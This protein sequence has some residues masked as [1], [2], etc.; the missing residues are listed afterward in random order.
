M[1]SLSALA[2]RVS[3]GSQQA[4]SVMRLRWAAIDL[5][6]YAGTAMVSGLPLTPRSPSGGEHMAVT[7]YAGS[8]S[9]VHGGRGVVAEYRGL[10]KLIVAIYWCLFAHIVIPGCVKP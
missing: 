4:R 10:D 3:D 7:L 5:A 8:L 1:A 2:V 6:L 9:I